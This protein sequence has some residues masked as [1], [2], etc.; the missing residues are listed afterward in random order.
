ML[1]LSQELN[2]FYGIIVFRG[3]GQQTV[4]IGPHLVHHLF[5]YSPQ[6]KNGFYSFFM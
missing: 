3:R 1:E 6:A 4:T 2:W 5:L